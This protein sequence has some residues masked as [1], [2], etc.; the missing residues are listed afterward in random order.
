M[1]VSFQGVIC[2]WFSDNNFLRILSVF[3]KLSVDRA[4]FTV[5]HVSM[6]IGPCD[7]KL[8]NVDVYMFIYLYCLLLDNIC[9]V[10]Y[11]ILY[12]CYLYLSFI[13]TVFTVENIYAF[14]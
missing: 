14:W 4:P 5:Y 10:S 11:F 1:A 2:V 6:D 7:F 12:I 8:N 9:S 13:Y 3:L